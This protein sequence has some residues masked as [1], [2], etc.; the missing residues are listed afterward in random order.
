MF[1]DHH[2]SINT[3]NC[4]KEKKKSYIEIK[5]YL[6]IYKMPK[7]KYALRICGSLYYLDRK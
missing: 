7:Y 2:T 1:L 4:E 6:F 5:F 3:N